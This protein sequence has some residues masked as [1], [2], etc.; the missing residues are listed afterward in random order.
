MWF[1]ASEEKPK[2]DISLE[3]GFKGMDLHEIILEGEY[4]QK[5][6]CGARCNPWTL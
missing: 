6:K 1:G 4:G 3:G 5:N 2:P